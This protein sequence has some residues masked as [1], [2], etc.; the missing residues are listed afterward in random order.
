MTTMG[1]VPKVEQADYIYKLI[2]RCVDFKCI[3]QSNALLQMSQSDGGDIQT[4]ATLIKYEADDGLEVVVKE[5]ANETSNN[6][7]INEQELCHFNN[8]SEG[9]ASLTQSSHK[10]RHSRYSAGCEVKKLESRRSRGWQRC[11]RREQVKF[12]ECHPA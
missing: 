6:E 4:T 10:R 7:V 9:E 12:R 2:S 5:E 8:Q 11:D 3:S 1:E